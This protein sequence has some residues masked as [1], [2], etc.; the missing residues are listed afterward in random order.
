LSAGDAD[1]SV[2]GVFMSFARAVEIAPNA[3]IT[4]QA[5]VTNNTL[6][7]RFCGCDFSQPDRPVQLRRPQACA[8]VRRLFRRTSL[9]NANPPPTFRLAAKAERAL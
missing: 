7:F 6:D 3:A 4:R 1:A 2:S 8:F 5:A 9:C